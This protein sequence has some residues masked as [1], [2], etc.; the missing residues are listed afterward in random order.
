MKT[1][2]EIKSMKIKSRR[3]RAQGWFARGA[4]MVMLGLVLCMAHGIWWMA[5]VAAG[6]GACSWALWVE[7]K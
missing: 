3:Q 6:L 7:D 5:L 2:N 1:P 4:L